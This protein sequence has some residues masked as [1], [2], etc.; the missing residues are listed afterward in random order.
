MGIRFLVAALFLNLAACAGN[1]PATPVIEP[2]HGQ[3]KTSVSTREQCK[4]STA[5]KCK[6]VVQQAALNEEME[7]WLFSACAEASTSAEADNCILEHYKAGFQLTPSTPAAC[8]DRGLAFQLICL[9]TGGEAYDLATRAG[10]RE[11]LAFDWSNWSATSALTVLRQ[12]SADA[13]IAM[14]RQKESGCASE[15]F[16]D[17][18]GLP[19]E[20]FA[21]CSAA[22]D[23]A[24]IEDCLLQAHGYRFRESALRRMQAS[25]GTAS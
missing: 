15:A 25:H 22:G 23:Q 11:A 20:D 21:H 4:T 13:C 6:F 18:L 7:T 10:M 9:D 12:Q 17:R 2:E 1:Q 19:R 24:A 14:K 8:I 3:A 5:P 16:A